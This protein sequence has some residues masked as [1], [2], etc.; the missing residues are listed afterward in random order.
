MG[1]IGH[2]YKSLVV[3]Q[4]SQI[5]IHVPFE[6]DIHCHKFLLD[7]PSYD[8]TSGMDE[9]RTNLG[10]GVFTPNFEDEWRRLESVLQKDASERV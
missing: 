3:D 10:Q 9:I 4:S 1:L 5:R 7:K 6:R 2:F 8:C